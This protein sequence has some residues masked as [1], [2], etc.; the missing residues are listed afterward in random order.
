[1]NLELPPEL[2]PYRARIEATVKPCVV[3]EKADGEPGL[4]DSKV[5]GV[6]YWPA[7][8]E[9]P[10]DSSGKPLYLL[11]QLNLD[12]LPKLEEF[13]HTGLLQFY[14]AGDDESCLY[15]YGADFR[16][17]ESGI[18]H[19]VIFH[20]NYK[21]KS[22]DMVLK[23]P[24][25]PYDIPFNS[26]RSYKLEGETSIQPISV[27]DNEFS[28]IMG[29]GLYDFDNPK[30][31]P[32]GTYETIYSARGHRFGG[33]PYFTQSDPREAE[34]TQ[35]LLFQLDSD[36]DMEVMWGDVGVCNFFINRDDLERLDFSRVMYNW[37]CS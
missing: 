2:E 17:P 9:Y 6:P 1:M 21:E 33:Y 35:V 12:D 32:H 34:N 20:A 25:Q 24:P 23:L 5:G 11:A 15:P 7:E 13:P 36:D 4:R 31:V 14:I 29:F 37:D 22:M 26:E 8:M 18:G 28:T 10:T 30:Y 3:L 27:Y 16:N 19:R